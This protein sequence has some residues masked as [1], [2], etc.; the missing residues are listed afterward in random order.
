[1]SDMLGMLDFINGISRSVKKANLK[2]KPGDGIDKIMV[3][4][5]FDTYKNYLWVPMFESFVTPGKLTFGYH[6][7]GYPEKSIT[8][9]LNYSHA[10][11]SYNWFKGQHKAVFE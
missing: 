9:P 10:Y 7:A 6:H 1:M 3:D 8:R 2:F 11:Y 4:L 5:N